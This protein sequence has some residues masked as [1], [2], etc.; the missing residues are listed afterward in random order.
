MAERRRRAVT[1]GDPSASAEAAGLR[2]VHDGVGGFTRHVTGKRVRIGKRWVAAFSYRDQNGRPVRDRATL[3]RIRALAIPPAWEAVWICGDARGHLQATGR[4]VRGRKQYRYHPRWRQE[5]DSTKYD[6][7]VEFGTALPAL[8][9]H[10]AADLRLPG[11]P[12]TKVLA[13]V[14]RLLETTF[15]RVGNEEYARSNGSYGLTTLKDRHVEVGRSRLRF[16]F[17]GKSGVFH[18]VDVRDPKLA[19]VV[20]RCRDLPG[21]VLFQYLDED[22][23]PARV[24]SADVNAYI[25]QCSGHEFT[26][27]D[28]R[29]W[30]GSVLAAVALGA[31][32]PTP[33]RSDTAGRRLR[34]NNREVV[35]AITEVARQLGNTPA[36][37]RK[38]YIHP[39]VISSYLEGRS[40]SM[41]AHA[42]PV[43]LGRVGLAPE[44]KAV[45]RLLRGC[46]RQEPG[47]DASLARQLRRSVATLRAAA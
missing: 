5:R 22:G 27:K 16:H 21:Q 10:V 2:H 9:R 23:R 34:P 37:C 44:E 45:L 13:A 4:D 7:M 3:D 8:R 29:T 33:T 35:Q 30:A 41:P 17:R 12:H 40:L 31:G 6:R 19:S 38:S 42:G 39:H 20:R 36:V 28:F 11:L 25:R 24:D 32:A 18:H 1:A 47:S 15:I 43:R 46:R 26:A 14:V